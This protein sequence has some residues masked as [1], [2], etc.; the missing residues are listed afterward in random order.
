MYCGR[1]EI[2]QGD[3]LVADIEELQ[4]MNAL[5]IHDGP[6]MVKNFFSRSQMEQSNYLEEIRFSEHSP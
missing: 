2:S 3:I 4:Q 6:K 5:E 1:W